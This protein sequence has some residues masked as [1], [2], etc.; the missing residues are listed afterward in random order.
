MSSEMVGAMPRR[1]QVCSALLEEN[2]E[3]HAAIL[4][5]IEARDSEAARQAMAAHVRSAGELVSRRLE[6][7]AQAE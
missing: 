6:Q 2:V 7:I 5:A 1:A 4:A 3:Q